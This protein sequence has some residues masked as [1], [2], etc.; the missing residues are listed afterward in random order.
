MRGWDGLSQRGRPWLPCSASE[1]C[2]RFS[3]RFATSV[4]FPGHGATYAL[5][6]FVVRPLA[7]SASNLINCAY[8]SDGGSQHVVCTPRG[9][10]PSCIPG[11]RKPCDRSLGVHGGWSCAWTGAS[12]LKHMLMQRRFA[13]AVGPGASSYNEL[14]LDASTWQRNLP[15]TIEGV[16]VSKRAN[17]QHRAHAVSVHAAF[18]RH[19]WAALQPNSFPLLEYDDSGESGGAPFRDITPVGCAGGGGAQTLDEIKR[20]CPCTSNNGG[21][22]PLVYC[23][24]WTG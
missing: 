15:T 23:D 22:V 19:Y 18:V 17:D 9:R 1:H 3:D 16:W 2:E 5:G 20:A 13:G 10:S 6:G 12:Q 14:V 7:G 11:C 21:N 24:S 8:A 4:V